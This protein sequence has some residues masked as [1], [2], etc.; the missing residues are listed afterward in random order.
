MSRISKIVSC[1]RVLVALAFGLGAAC[2][3]PQSGQAAVSIDFETLEDFEIVT[4][5]Y[6]GVG[7]TFSNA[8]AGM[9]GAAGG[10]L[11]EIDFPPTSGV[12][13]VTNE[14]DTDSDGFPD[15]V[16]PMDIMFGPQ[17]FDSVS[18]W[19]VYS[20]FLGS[21]ELLTLQAFSPTDSLNPL[22]TLTLA[23]NLGSP[24]QLTFS[25]LGPIG[26][27]SIHGGEGSYF[28]L[29]D[30]AGVIVPEP[31]SILLMSFGFAAAIRRRSRRRAL[32]RE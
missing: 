12:T 29:D 6:V 4:T 13:L 7:A 22:A 20:D 30:L 14:V 26:L 11:N 31:S 21:G 25:G 5:Q 16:G 24:T 32:I 10:T 27:V 9:S 17:P 18:G 23:E 8:T 28:T 19:F 2:L 3:V 15:D 1:Q